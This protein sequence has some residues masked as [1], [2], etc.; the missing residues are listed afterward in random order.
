MKEMWSGKH[1]VIAPRDFKNTIGQFQPSFAGYSQQDAQEFLSYLVDGIHEDLN[2]IIKKPTTVNPEV[3]DRNEEEV[4]QEAWD[5]HMKRN[6]SMVVDKFHGQIKSTLVC[7]KCDNVAVV[8]QPFLY[9]SLPLPVEKNR[10]IPI[11]LFRHDNKSQTTKYAIKVQ[12]AGLMQELRKA[13]SEVTG[14]KANDIVIADVFHHRIYKFFT[15]SHSIG[16]ISDS[17]VVCAYELPNLSEE[18]HSNTESAYLSVKFC[19]T[20]KSERNVQEKLAALGTPFA[21]PFDSK[22]TTKKE[23]YESALQFVSR[24]LKDDIS[25]FFD[26]TNLESLFPTK[27]SEKK[28]FLFSLRSDSSYNDD[29]EEIIFEDEIYTT[30][31]SSYSSSSDKKLIMFIDPQTL[32]NVVDMEKFKTVIEHESLNSK[33]SSKEI[34]IDDCIEMFT[35]TETLGPDDPWYCGKCKNFVQAE[36]KLELWKLPDVLIV[37]LKRFSFNKYSRDKLD[38][39]VNFPVEDLDLNKYV[40]SK[41]EYNYDLHGITD[42]YVKNIFL[43]TF[44][45]GIFRWRTLHSCCKSW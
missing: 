14:I 44:L 41:G 2:R 34:S 19:T 15:D 40:L 5:L 27:D 42:H 33:L 30:S 16:S 6:N 31:K 1:S 18:A 23:L 13:I 38:T 11:T 3:S 22:K 12:K 17:D 4:A 35:S 9:L 36:K 45:S 25:E 32:G 20:E 39:L 29:S 21:L 26:L 37:H 24:Y 28:N 8:F 7:P 43:L 10:I